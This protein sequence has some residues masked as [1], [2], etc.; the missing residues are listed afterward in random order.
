MKVKEIMETE[1]IIIPADLTYE[2]VAREL[3]EKKISGAPVVDRTGKLI[4]VI[5]EKDLFRLLYP[6]YRDFYKHP[7]AYLDYELREEKIEELKQR[8]IAEIVNH[9]VYTIHPDA[10]VL[11]AG[12]LML[13]HGLHRLPV[14]QN[15]V[16]VGIV[17]RDHIFRGILKKHLAL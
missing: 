16:L 11:R 13:S 4:G 7:E 12:S 3:Y 17:T 2:E 10:P 15:D 5:S 8:P 6:S 14:V 9:Q 1:I